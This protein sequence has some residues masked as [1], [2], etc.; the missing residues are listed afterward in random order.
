[1]I[2]VG[3]DPFD[4]AEE[5]V[6]QPVHLGQALPAQG[7]NPAEQEVQDARSGLVHPEP[8]ELLA[9][10][11]RFEEPPIGREERL[12]L[13]PFRTTDR[14]PAPQKEPALASPVF[15]HHGAGAEELLAGRR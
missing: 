13:S 1:M 3:G 6:A 15:P 9:Q 5:E 11:I 8:I 12:Q 14:L 2:A 10:D 4:V 7:L